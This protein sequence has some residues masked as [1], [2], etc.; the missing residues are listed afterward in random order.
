LREHFPP[1]L[2]D[3]LRRAA[4]AGGSEAELA[5]QAQAHPEDLMPL[6]ILVER[7]HAKH[8]G[9]A[10]RAWLSR[11]ESADKSKDRADAARAAWRRTESDLREGLI[12]QLRARTLAYLD[13]YPAWAHSA[14]PALAASGADRATLER[15]FTRAIDA[16]QLPPPV[17]NKLTYEALAVG[18]LDA[19]LH[20][21]EKQLA[22][23]PKDPNSYDTL[24][25]VYNYR[26]DKARALEL[27]RQGLAIE[28]A[29]PDLV[30]AMRENLKR[31][32]IGG[33]CK[34][35]LGAPVLPEVLVMPQPSANALGGNKA[36][37]R[38]LFEHAAAEIGQGCGKQSKGL[39][40]AYVRVQV[41]P[42]PHIGKVEVLEPQASPALRKCL[43]RALREVAIPADTEPAR[44]TFAIPLPSPPTAAA[45]SATPAATSPPAMR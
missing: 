18:A 6:W 21:A 19:A 10:E 29:P 9:A 23:A 12:A 16:A 26:R 39:E 4:R 34:D 44:V 41:G 36:A 7:A 45:S 30:A 27:E 28:G 17:L 40:E 1:K 20:A 25:E 43:E 14:L 11:I 42:N 8:D 31:F 5:A 22:A 13:K 3:W 35:V 38:R 15:A 33:P 24:A 32:E 2:T 37:T